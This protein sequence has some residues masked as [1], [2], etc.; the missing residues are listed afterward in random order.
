MRTTPLIALT[1][2][3]LLASAAANADPAGFH[4][5]TA[6]GRALLDEQ[7]DDGTRIDTD[8]TAFR[9]TLGYRFGEY[10]GLEA[11]YHR[12]GDFRQ[13]AI[14]D[15]IP[16]EV[17]IGADGFTAAVTG[18]LPLGERFSVLGRAGLFF[19]NGTAQINGVSSASPDDTNLLLG[20]GLGYRVASPLTLTADVSHYDLEDAQST[21][22]S[23]GLEYR[24][25][26]R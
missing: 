15:G 11:G 8:S 19:W 5:G 1:L 20:L 10:L 7:F 16:A 21:V 12:F 9:L 22:F 24:F 25:G 17:S 14:V 6:V 23:L 2:L 4:L 13:D 3:A 26:A 18:R